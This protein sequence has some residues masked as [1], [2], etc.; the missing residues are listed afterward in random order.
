MSLELPEFSVVRD[1]MWSSFDLHHCPCLACYEWICFFDFFFRKIKKK[2][3]HTTRILHRTC[4]K[5]PKFTFGLNGTSMALLIPPPGE[6][7]RGCTS[8]EGCTLMKNINSRM[9]TLKAKILVAWCHSYVWFKSHPT[10][11]IINHFWPNFTCMQGL[12]WRFHPI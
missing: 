12:K 2:F 9:T 5:H 8:T 1:Q 11:I 4:P 3:Q 10:K 6:K 7:K